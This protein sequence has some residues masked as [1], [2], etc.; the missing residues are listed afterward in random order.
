MMK[1]LPTDRQY[2]TFL[3]LDNKPSSHINPPNDLHRHLYIKYQPSHQHKEI[4][5]IPRNL[6]TMPFT[7]WYFCSVKKTPATTDE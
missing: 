3:T 5:V 7:P 6:H 4:L 1:A 2:F